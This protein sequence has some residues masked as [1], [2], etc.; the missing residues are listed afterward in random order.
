[1]QGP[2]EGGKERKPGIDEEEDVGEHATAFEPQCE[3][4]GK[5]WELR[6]MRLIELAGLFSFEILIQV[7]HGVPLERGF[8]ICDGPRGPRGRDRL[9]LR[10][11][12]LRQRSVGGRRNAF[13]ASF[14]LTSSPRC[15]FPTRLLVSTSSSCGSC[16]SWSTSCATP[17][18]S[19]LQGRH[20]R[21]SQLAGALC[22][23]WRGG[24]GA[25]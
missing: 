24:V 4:A 1:M 25:M 2:K 14:V 20:G 6:N 22:A 7:K 8:R 21:P 10:W 15:P 19:S 12:G 11:S 18:A 13:F 16:K 9:R 23:C 5:Y 3:M 17:K